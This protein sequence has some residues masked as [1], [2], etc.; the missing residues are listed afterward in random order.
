MRNKLIN[1]IGS[2]E[3]IANYSK[4]G[5]FLN[6]PIK[7]IHA[8]FHRKFIYS[9][10]KKEKIIGTDLFWGSKMQIALPASTDIYLTGGKSH[11]SEIRLAKFIILNMTEGSHFLDIGA[12]YGYFTLLASH[13]AGNSGKIMSFEPAENSHKLLSI[14]TKNLQNTSVFKLAVSKSIGTL[15]FYEFPNLHS[16]YNSSDVSQFEN[17]SWFTNSKPIK[18]EVQAT[19]IDAITG[20]KPFFAQLIKIDVEGGEFDVIEGGIN[21]LKNHSP[22]IIMEYLEPNRKNESHKK[23]LDLL[24]SIGYTSNLITKDGET[25]PIDDIDGYLI[26]EGLESDNIVFIKM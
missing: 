12:H 11:S 20:D 15:I 13:L 3:K 5:R 16:E 4:V 14:N 18:V 6:N 23:A 24:L 26:R 7:Y 25:I 8:I 19:T 1:Q 17:E 2:V 10:S 9:N 22:K 21:Y